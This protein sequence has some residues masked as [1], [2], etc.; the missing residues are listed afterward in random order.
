MESERERIDTRACVNV[1]MQNIPTI[2]KTTGE[3]H[4]IESRRKTY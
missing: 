4:T 2:K 3:R 1:A